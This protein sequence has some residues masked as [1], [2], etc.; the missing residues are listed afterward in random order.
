MS[1]SDQFEK[2]I[3][4]G[5]IKFAPA[6]LSDLTNWGKSLVI[7]FLDRAGITWELG[8]VRIGGAYCLKLNDPFLQ[9]LDVLED[10]GQFMWCIDDHHDSIHPD[11]ASA[12]IMVKSFPDFQ[13]RCER[14]DGV[15]RMIVTRPDGVEFTI[16]DLR[17]KN[18]LILAIQRTK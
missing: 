15:R 16:D 11:E 14:T 5:G 4:E 13:I 9:Y 12:Y 17:D 7:A 1:P 2:L 3:A 18:T 8:D 10:T 6:P